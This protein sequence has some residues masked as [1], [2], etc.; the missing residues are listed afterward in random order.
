MYKFQEI[1]KHIQD[2]L[3]FFVMVWP[4][5]LI[6]GLAPFLVSILSGEFTF[7]IPIYIICAVLW[8]GAIII[9]YLIDK[10]L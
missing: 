5:L 1:L 3:Y 2:K 10:V 9:G 4:I 7:I 6:I 8:I